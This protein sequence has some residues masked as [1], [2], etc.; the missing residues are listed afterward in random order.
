MALSG[1]MQS[2]AMRIFD[3]IGRP[4]LKH[5]HKFAT[6]DA[7]VEHRD[8]LDELIGAFIRKMTREEALDL[9]EAEGVTVG[10][11]CSMAELL[12]HSYVVGREALV[13]LPDS[14]MGAVPMHNVV[15][16]FSNTPGVFRRPAPTLGEHND[17]IL[18]E[19]RASRMAKKEQL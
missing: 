16:R 19:I 12:E 11:V 5:D 10:P 15:P 14:E 17:E 13:D 9:F 2:M 6:N 1:S 7:R 8:E 3:T 4:E 18:S